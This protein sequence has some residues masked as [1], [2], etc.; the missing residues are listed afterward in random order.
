MFRFFPTTSIASPPSP[1]QPFVPSLY[2]KEEA[3]GAKVQ[4]MYTR[5]MY[6]LYERLRRSALSHQ[7]PEKRRGGGPSCFC[8]PS[9]P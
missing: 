4:W 5:G 7:A 1:V 2:E 6:G 3:A 9:A 8:P